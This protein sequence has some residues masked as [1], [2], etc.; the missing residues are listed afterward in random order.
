MFIYIDEIPAGK[1]CINLKKHRAL[2]N[3]PIL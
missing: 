2:F 1:E 3:A